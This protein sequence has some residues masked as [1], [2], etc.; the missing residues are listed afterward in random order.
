[1]AQKPR[2]APESIGCI[3]DIT[4]L[5]SISTPSVS[6]LCVGVGAQ[7]LIFDVSTGKE[8]AKTCWEG[9]VRIHGIRAS[10]LTE[11]IDK[12]GSDD[13]GRIAAD[14]AADGSASASSASSS[15]ST[16]LLVA[17]GDR[18]AAAY[19]LSVGR[20][21]S[22]SLEETWR[23]SFGAWTLDAVPFSS[24]SSSSE[25]EEKGGGAPVVV[26]VGAADGSVALHRVPSSSSSSSSSSPS[27]P[28]SSL[29]LESRCAERCLL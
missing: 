16:F 17:H 24:S 11:E 18:G 2:G 9:G 21:S 28:D 26:A 7:I 6:L 12:R 1:M 20:D 3:G 22:A 10:K 19:L 27:S 8:L 5:A 4:A 25:A 13:D 23:R 14:A 29:I 15:A